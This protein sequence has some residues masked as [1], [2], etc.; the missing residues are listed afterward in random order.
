MWEVGIERVS[1]RPLLLR[2]LSLLLQSK[3]SFRTFLPIVVIGQ[4][5]SAS[6]LIDRSPA[7]S[8]RLNRASNATAVVSAGQSTLLVD[9]IKQKKLHLQQLCRW[10]E[11]R[12]FKDAPLA[13]FGARWFR[14]AST[15]TIE[16]NAGH[17]VAMIGIPNLLFP[18]LCSI[19]LSITTIWQGRG[20][21]CR[22]ISLPS[23]SSV[24]SLTPVFT[25]SFI[26]VKYLLPFVQCLL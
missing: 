4:I 6:A 7:T 21:V 20:H 17:E 14:Q 22:W 9:M 3:L 15:V 23:K 12:L 24:S 2:R 1:T 25:F 16:M 13:E 18:I 10:Y 11:H 8:C 19:L 26:V 5:V